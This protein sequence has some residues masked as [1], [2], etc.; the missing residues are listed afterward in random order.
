MIK[1]NLIPISLWTTDWRTIIP[2][3]FSQFCEG[4]NPTSG[5]PAWGSDKAR[6]SGVEGQWD[7]IIGFPEDWEKQRL[8]Y[9]GP[10]FACTKTQR[11]GAGTHR[12]LN[13]NY[14]L[15][16]EGLLWRHWL[17]GAHQGMGRWKVALM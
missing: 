11:R 10:H 13:Q 15:V 4:S 6:E 3:Q 2:T 5:F 7:L 1:L 14:L 17:A 12:K 16:L 8:Q 9:G